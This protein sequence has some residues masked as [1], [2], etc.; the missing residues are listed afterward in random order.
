MDSNYGS[1]ILS[2]DGKPFAYVNASV[3]AGPQ[4]QQTIFQINGLPSGEHTIRISAQDTWIEVDA[5]EYYV[6]FTE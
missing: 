6:M 1:A 3:S 2:V 5:F 4:Y